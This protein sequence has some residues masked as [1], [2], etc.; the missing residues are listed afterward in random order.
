[1][2]CDLQWLCDAH[3][4]L[5]DTRSDCVCVEYQGTMD[6]S[7]NYAKR[8]RFTYLAYDL[9]RFS[10]VNCFQVLL[11]STIVVGLLIKKVAV[12]A[13]YHILPRS[14]HSRLLCQ[15]NGRYEQVSLI[16]NFQPLLERL[17]M[18]SEDLAY[19]SAL[20]FAFVVRRL[21]LPSCVKVKR[22][23]LIMNSVLT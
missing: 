18:I 23:S 10:V 14:I 19:I 13:K 16:Q 2:W 11:H 7:D 1:M 6:I 9:G 20:C 8:N 3:V 4:I 12:F 15:A 5:R 22:S 21:T 17:L